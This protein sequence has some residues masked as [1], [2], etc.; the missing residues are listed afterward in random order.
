MYGQRLLRSP[1]SAVSEQGVP[2]S[3]CWLQLTRITLALSVGQPYFGLQQELEPDAKGAGLWGRKTGAPAEGPCKQKGLHP[4]AA[5]TFTS[6]LFGHP[7][8]P[9]IG[10]V[11]GSLVTVV[12]LVS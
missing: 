1:W 11:R 9:E 4:L 2:C 6:E 8:T 7:G 3:L 5:H 10:C 12:P